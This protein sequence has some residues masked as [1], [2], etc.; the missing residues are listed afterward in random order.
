MKTALLWY[1]VAVNAIAFL[2]YGWDK[3]QARLGRRRVPE[4]RLLWL[5]FLLGAPGSWF[6]T[7]VF[8]HKTVKVSF[9][10]KLLFV[11]VLEVVLV[12]AAIWWF[13]LRDGAR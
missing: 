1:L 6:A 9:R 2:V 8:R 4:S 10:L 7:K 3:R 13:W 11:T 5:A 12:G